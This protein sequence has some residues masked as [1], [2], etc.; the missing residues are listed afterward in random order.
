M[1]FT[2]VV[3]TGQRDPVSEFTYKGDDGSDVVEEDIGQLIRRLAHIIELRVIGGMVQEIDHTAS[4]RTRYPSG[5]QFT[6][7]GGSVVLGLSFGGE[8]GVRE[9]GEVNNQ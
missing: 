5:E 8:T 9:P 1:H 2:H 3:I 4:F 6:S 7:L